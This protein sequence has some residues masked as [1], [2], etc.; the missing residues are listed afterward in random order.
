MESMY[1]GKGSVQY[2]RVLGPSVFLTPWAYV[3]QMV[4]PPGASIGAHMHREVGE[5][6][7]V[8]KGQGTAHVG[9]ESAPIREGDGLA[10]QLGEM[11]SFE[12][13]GAEPLEML[14]AGVSRDANRTIDVVEGG[15]GGRRN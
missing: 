13:T 1:G 5:V 15:R 12:N 2:R 10:L 11:H 4:L 6:F 14:V 9:S 8:V 3:D 7:F